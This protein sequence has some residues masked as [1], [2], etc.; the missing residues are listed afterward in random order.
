MKV[1]IPI[2]SETENDEVFLER[3]LEGAKEIILLLVVDAN[4]KEKFGFTTAHIS[5]ARTVMEDLKKEVGKK[6]KTAEDVLEWGDTHS[7]VLNMALLRKVDKV[8]LKRQE[9]QYFEQLVKKLEGERVNVE[10]I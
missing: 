3:A 9:N 10:V 8:V 4:P 5:K 2:L 6:R 1:L 7:K